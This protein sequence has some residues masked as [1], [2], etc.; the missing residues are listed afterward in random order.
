[1]I[2]AADG[3]SSDTSAGSAVLSAVGDVLVRQ[4]DVVENSALMAELVAIE[5]ALD[6]QPTVIQTDSAHS[7]GMLTGVY[8]P[9]KDVA[10]VVESILC[11]RS[12]RAGMLQKVRSHKGNRL[13]NQA[14]SL[15]VF[16]RR[17]VLP[18]TEE[19]HIDDFPMLDISKWY[20]GLRKAALWMDVSE[21]DLLDM[22]VSGGL[23]S[24]NSPTDEALCGGFAIEMGGTV[25]WHSLR[26][27]ERLMSLPDRLFLELSRADYEPTIEQVIRRMSSLEQWTP[28]MLVR[29]IAKDGRMAV[30][31]D[32]VTLTL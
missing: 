27:A 2:V 16:A 5:I 25:N 22:M 30:V 8:K 17:G 7:I 23:S 13:H 10:P 11:H 18:E 24:D 32:R 19:Y 28:R 4:F 26:L 20:L 1:M 14:D 9:G 15:A 3:A 21:D 6:L 12:W 29:A 31:E